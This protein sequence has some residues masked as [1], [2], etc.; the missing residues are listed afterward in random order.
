MTAERK[1]KKTYRILAVDDSPDTL[2][3][4]QRNLQTHGYQVK[5]VTSAEAALDFLKITTVDLLITD[6]KMPRVSGLDLLK[7]ITENHKDIE[8][9]MITG[10]PCVDG[11]VQAIKDGA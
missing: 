3:V 5:T 7:H 8:V 4:I 6:Y 10:Y 11:A 2:E 9:M 1:K